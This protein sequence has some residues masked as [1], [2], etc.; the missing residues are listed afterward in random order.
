M[1]NF[2]D[3]LKKSVDTGEF[4]SEAAKKIN[5]IDALADN[6][7]GFSEKDQEKAR[8]VLASEAV[9]PEEALELNSK[10]EQEM[11]R[12]KKVD[13]INKQIATLLDIEDMVKL[14][15][16]DMLSF[17]SELEQK[18]AKDLD[19]KNPMFDDLSLAIAKVKNVYEPTL[20]E[21]VHKEAQKE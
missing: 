16:G 20:V 18:F 8:Q 1:S 19:E 6:A 7:K 12:I 5:A 4:N 21:Y 9:S 14:S 10:Y 15:I 13:A 11:E 3:D 17:V 2:L